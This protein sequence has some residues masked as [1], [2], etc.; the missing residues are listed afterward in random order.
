MSI[1]QKIA[2]DLRMHYL[3]LLLWRIQIQQGR[4]EPK[5]THLLRSFTLDHI[6]HCQ[7]LLTKTKILPHRNR[8]E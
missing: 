2:R 3:Q 8:R 1:P 4:L 5:H 6:R 7:S